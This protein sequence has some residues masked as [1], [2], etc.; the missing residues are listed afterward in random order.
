MKDSKPIDKNQVLRIVDKVGRKN[1]VVSVVARVW[2]V[3]GLFLPLKP[4]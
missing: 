1:R 2:A 4:L 3:K